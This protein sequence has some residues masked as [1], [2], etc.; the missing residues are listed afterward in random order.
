M[1]RANGDYQY[2]IGAGVSFF[3]DLKE[4]RKAVRK[5]EGWSIKK[6]KER[7]KEFYRAKVKAYCRLSELQIGV[8][9]KLPGAGVLVSPS[10]A[11]YFY[12]KMRKQK[13]GR[14]KAWYYN[15]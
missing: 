3:D 10:E 6:V 7:G 5:I 8:F 4:W 13:P 12:A 14:T 9:D 2:D 1:S 15:S 11:Q